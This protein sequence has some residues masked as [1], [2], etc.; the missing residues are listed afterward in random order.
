MKTPELKTNITDD[1]VKTMGLVCGLEIHQQLEGKKLFAYTP[2]RIRDDA[3]DYEV[4]RFIRAA[5]G[6]TGVVDA[7]AAAEVKKQKYYLYEG[8]N[9][10]ISLVELDEEPPVPLNPVA[11]HEALALAKLFGMRA[12]D[13]V[14][15]MRKTVVDGSNTSG[16]QR[17]GLVAV[18]GKIS[19]GD[20]RIDSLCLEEDSCKKVE[21]TTAYTKYN[22]SRLGIPLIEIATA[23]D[24]TSPQQ[25]MD[26]A[27]YI[28]MALRSL[29]HCKRGLGTIRQ[30]VN[31]SIKEGVRVEIKGAQDLK[32]IPT[33]VENEMLRQYNLSRIFETLKERNADVGD[34]QDIT[35]V[36]SSTGAKLI[37]GALD[38]K[39]VV[40]GV[41]LKGFA[42]IVGLEVQSGRRYGSELS[43]YAKVMGVKGLIHSDEDLEGK[44]GIST[45]EVVNIKN[46][47]GVGDG[48]AFII[49]AAP[50]DVATRAIAAAIDRAKDFTLRKEVR[51]ARPNGTTSYMRPMPGAARMYPETD[52]KPVRTAEIEVSVPKLLDEQIKDVMKDFGLAQEQASRLLRD[53]IDLYSLTTTY[54]NIKP[55]FILDFYY[56]LPSQVK[57]KTGKDVDMSLYAQEVLT[58][59]NDGS[60]T[61]DALLDIVAVL[62]QGKT[63]NYAEYEPMDDGAIETVIKQIL[64]QNTGAPTGAL[65]GKAMAQ[66]KGKVDGKTVAALI[67]KLQ[68]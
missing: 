30:D 16:F 32:M 18:N 5:A 23:P 60:I 38:A 22:L 53:G 9:D 24:I 35:G 15:F 44:Y 63:V 64:E 34:A 29:K 41:A 55:A 48:D 3:P 2:T 57:K 19:V 59:I 42:G 39:G 40:M 1:D 47:L 21:E 65:M 13:E 17:T 4:K 20:V 61:K 50:K 37:K 27:S 6:E 33:L 26:V 68:S 31:V 11:L 10:T 8:Y 25:A 14:R 28:G 54:P 7:A 49:I 12:I 62:S 46:N 52:V 67:K 66:L 58:K 51:V 43:D 45:V 36:F 56:S